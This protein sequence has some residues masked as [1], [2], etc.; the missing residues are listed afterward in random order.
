MGV[1]LH[2][3]VEARR[4][5]EGKGNAYMVVNFVVIVSDEEDCD[6]AGVSVTEVHACPSLGAAKKRA[7]KIKADRAPYD[8]VVW[9]VNTNEAAYSPYNKET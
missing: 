6:D 4:L 2:R 8:I 5:G 1:V 7:D 3:V 9:D